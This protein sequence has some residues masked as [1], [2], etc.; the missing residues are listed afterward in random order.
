V[1]YVP[2]EGE[3][4]FLSREAD[5]VLRYRHSEEVGTMALSG[6]SQLADM[7]EAED[8]YILYGEGRF[9]Y[10]AAHAD[11]WTCEVGGSYET[12]LED[13]YFSHVATADFDADGRLDLVAVDGNEHVVEILR[14]EADG[15][16]SQMHWEI[17]EQNMH[18]QGRTGAKLEPRQTVTA[19]FNDDGRMD[20]AFLIHDRIIFY[21]QE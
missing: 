8:T 21:L 19:D 2:K 4:Q 16:R 3:L 18:Y 12:G 5:G 11:S 13:V 20:F 10:F 1:L 9:W 14:H 6:W 17:F 7:E 15:M